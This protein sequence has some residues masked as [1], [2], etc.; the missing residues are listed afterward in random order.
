[1]SA[2]IDFS[3][4]EKFRRYF[5]QFGLGTET[6]VDYPY[7]ATGFEGTN[8]M[9]G[10]LLDFAIGQYDTYTALQLAQYVSTIAN[11]GYR[12]RPRF[13]KEIREPNGTED[14]LGAIYRKENTT[15]LNKIEMDHVERVQEG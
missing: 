4:F 8:P 2:S 9:A 12:V 5:Q 7:E 6:G 3:G 11:D 14:Q 10:N 13:L 15:V 1:K